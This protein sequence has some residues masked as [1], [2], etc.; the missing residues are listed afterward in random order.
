MWTIFVGRRDYNL[1]LGLVNKMAL[2]FIWLTIHLL[3]CFQF[4]WKVRYMVFDHMLLKRFVD[5]TFKASISASS[6]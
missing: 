3:L 4:Y 6:G 1:F 5:H 2:N